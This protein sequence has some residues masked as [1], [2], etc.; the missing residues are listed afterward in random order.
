VYEFFVTGDGRPMTNISARGSIVN[1]PSTYGDAFFVNF[2]E[3]VENFT[4]MNG[5]V[6]WYFPRNSVVHIEVRAAGY[7]VI[8]LVPEAES[9]RVKDMEDA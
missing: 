5:R 6:D 7:S 3:A 2:E 1:L 8:K 9:I 4:D